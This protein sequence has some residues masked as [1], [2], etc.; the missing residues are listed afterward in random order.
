MPIPEKTAYEQLV[1]NLADAHPEITR[2]TLA[3]Y[4]VSAYTAIVE[5]SL[6]FATGLEL[7]ILEALDFRRARIQRYSYTVF[8][9]ADKVRWYDPEPHPENPALASTFPHHF[10]D[11]PDQKNNRRPSPGIAFD[12]PNFATLIADCIALGES[13]GASQ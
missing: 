6:F 10:H 8:R 3:L 12:A 5:G 13:L 2:S 1:Y 9:G 11:L 4:T 7:R